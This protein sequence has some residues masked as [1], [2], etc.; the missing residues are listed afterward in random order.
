MKVVIDTNIIFSALLRGGQRYRDILFFENAEFYSCKY[1]IVEIFKHK[2]KI[3]K[4]SKQAEEVVLEILYRILKNIHIVNEEL[5]SKERLMEAY[6]LCQDIDEK[7]SVFV[8]LTL[9]LDGVL[10]TGDKKLKE[11]L[12]KKR[13]GRFFEKKIR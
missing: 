5:I 3:V 9:E 4:C 10:W 1:T 13:F 12:K 6:D 7:D 2:E 11:G 8:A